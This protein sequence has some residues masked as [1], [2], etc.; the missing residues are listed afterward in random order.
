MADDTA[1]VWPAAIVTVLLIAEHPPSTHVSESVSYDQSSYCRDAP[2]S[3]C[4]CTDCDCVVVFL[5]PNASH[6]RSWSLPRYPPIDALTPVT[7][8][9][10]DWATARRAN[11]SPAISIRLQMRVAKE[12]VERRDTG[13]LR[14]GVGRD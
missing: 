4:T 13:N 14:K 6:P 2:Q 5:T 9:G 1:S 3:P 8:I 12:R 7:M 10:A 11:T